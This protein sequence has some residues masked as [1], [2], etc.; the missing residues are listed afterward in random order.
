[1]HAESKGTKCENLGVDELCSLWVFAKL[2]QADDKAHEAAGVRAKGEEKRGGRRVTGVE[3]EV[4]N[5]VKGKECTSLH[6]VVVEPFLDKRVEVCKN[7]L[8]PLKALLGFDNALCFQCFIQPFGSPQVLHC[9]ASAKQNRGKVVCAF[10]SGGGCVYVRACVR[11]CVCV[12]A[13]VC[14][15]V[16]V[17]VCVCVCACVRVCV[18]VCVKECV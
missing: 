4:G 3:E 18:R 6:R 17:C 15:C 7:T 12:C 1:M 11:A 2:C 13:C 10:V 14:A 8:A 9:L 16:R 5:V